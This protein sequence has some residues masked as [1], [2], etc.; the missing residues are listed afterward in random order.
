ME[1]EIGKTAGAICQALS[2]QGELSLTQLKNQVKANAP[3]RRL[4]HRLAGAR[5][6]DCDHAREAL[7]PNPLE[8][9]ARKGDGLWFAKSPQELGL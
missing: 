6:P 1:E 5:G 7:F 3:L 2:T 8:R 9:A 4:G